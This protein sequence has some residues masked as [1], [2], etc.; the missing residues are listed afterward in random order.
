M[1]VDVAPK[2]AELRRRHQLSQS[3]SLC[4]TGDCA[5]FG[6]AEFADASWIG[7][8]GRYYYWGDRDAHPAPVFR[9]SFTCENPD[10]CRLAITCG[11]YYYA[12]LNGCPVTDAR[13][14]PTP[15]NYDRAVHW[16]AYDVSG[17]VCPGTNVL[18]V[19]LG[20]GFYNY[21]L[22]DNFR[23]DEAS[24][25]DAPCLIARL[26]DGNG[27]TVVATDASWEVYTDGP[28]R[29]DAI[30]RGTI[31]DARKERFDP[32][33]WAN[34]EKKHGVGGEFRKARH[35]PVRVIARHPMRRLPTGIWDSG[36][37]AAGVCELRVKGEAGAEVTLAHREDLAPDGSLL[38][39]DNFQKGE[40]MTDHYILRGDPA[41]ET[42]TPRFT[43]HGF[44]YVRTEIKGRA[45][46]TGLTQLALSSDFR[47]VG[48]IETSDADLM[49]LQRAF[50]WSYRSNFV[51][52]PTDCPTREKQGWSGDALAAC[53]SGLYN[54]DAADGYGDWLRGFA[55]VQRPNGQIPC[56][57]PISANGFNWGYGPAWD[58]ALVLIPWRIYVT[59]GDLSLA[60]ELYPAIRK[61]REFAQTMMTDGLAVGFGLGD[62]CDP[63]GNCWRRTDC[64][65]ANAT[66][67]NYFGLVTSAK[68]A[69]RLG[70][71]A[72]AARWLDEA[73]GVK[74]SFRAAYCRD[75]GGVCGDLQTDL[76]LAIAFGLATDEGRTLRKLVETV[77][78]DG[79]LQ[80]FGI[81]GAKYVPRVLA[82]HGYAEDALKILK[83]KDYPSILHYLNEGATTLWESFDGRLSRNH[84]MFGD[85]SAWMFRYLGG[86]DF[87]E[88]EPGRLTVAPVLLRDVGAFKAI[89]R[90]VESAWKFEDDYCVYRLKVSQ[91]ENVTLCLPGRERRLVGPGE[92]VREILDLS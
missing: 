48:T 67:Y 50:L 11:G 81:F 23:M 61:Y 41:G 21:T 49:R 70:E 88:N 68:L 22:E 87:D 25:R 43:Y 62:W 76:A 10:G 74:R 35:P 13:L 84:V 52:Y 15:S 5:S 44:R 19:T 28:F 90:G 78:K 77:R 1:L 2:G 45:E 46:V 27:Q 51:G 30:R 20:N 89:Y 54:F 9:K 60:R 91:G 57:S 38:E 63:D 39:F 58:E 85:L 53:A 6:G 16:S 14:T 3:Q 56:K 29:F 83:A 32:A 69:A 47:T 86:F 42:W 64:V 31:Y 26:S 72:D 82:D 18:V 79:H 8:K 92:T 80:K 37:N 73:D 17:L 55:D 12:E 59:S 66:A 24:W 33:G 4:V 65:T 71:T 75:D 7:V 40:F 34:A 36:Q